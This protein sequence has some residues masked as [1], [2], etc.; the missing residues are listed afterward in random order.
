MGK[1]K[2]AK[3]TAKSESKKVARKAKNPHTGSSFDDFALDNDSDTLASRLVESFE[4]A[5]RLK[6]LPFINTEDLAPNLPPVTDLSYIGG[7]DVLPPFH[8]GLMAQAVA[9]A[10]SRPDN[11][12]VRVP[13]GPPAP[14]YVFE[15]DVKATIARIGKR[16]EEVETDI[17]K[18]KIRSSQL[19]A[20]I[21]RLE[22]QGFFALFLKSLKSLF[23]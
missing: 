20:R 6:L 16:L 19:A 7:V 5:D 9:Q 2:T 15:D 18:E 10:Q 17:S 8:V 13:D 1:K 22:N 23:N 11:E 14:P 3:K 4:A 21:I 12:P